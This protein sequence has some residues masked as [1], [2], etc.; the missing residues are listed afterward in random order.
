MS[1]ARGSARTKPVSQRGSASAEVD[2]RVFKCALG[3]GGPIQN[4]K[5]FCRLQRSD[6]TRRRGSR[7]KKP[8]AIAR[9]SLYLSELMISPEGPSPYSTPHAAWKWP[10]A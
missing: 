4:Q 1:G 9:G 10:K 3:R 7:K 8:Q 2:G 6:A 5:R